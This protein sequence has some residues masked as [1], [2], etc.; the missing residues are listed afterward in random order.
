MLRA[1][2]CVVLFGAGVVCV[3]LCVCMPMGA[4]AEARGHA[5]Y[6]SSGTVSFGLRQLAGNKWPVSS[7]CPCT[8]LLLWGLGTQIQALSAYMASA[9]FKCWAH[10]LALMVILSTVTDGRLYL[11]K[12][13]IS[14]FVRIIDYLGFVLIC[15]LLCLVW[16]NTLLVGKSNSRHQQQEF[17]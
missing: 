2:L 9:L 5:W 1:F 7:W 13:L 14:I 17:G 8:C 15:L 12:H 4:R 6:W 11:I 16:E 3:F 10:A